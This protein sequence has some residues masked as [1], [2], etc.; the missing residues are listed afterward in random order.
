MKRYVVT[1]AALSALL[2]ACG[3]D[4]PAP[5][6]QPAAQ[7]D[8]AAPSGGEPQKDPAK[9]EDKTQ[10]EKPAEGG[11]PTDPTK[12]T[13]AP[14]TGDALPAL[15]AGAAPPERPALTPSSI[16]TLPADVVA[17]GGTPSLSALVKAFTSQASR[18][19]GVQ[20]PP[21]PIS[22][23]LEQL[24]KEAGIDL[25]WL[26]ADK[27]LRFAVPDPKKYPDAFVLLLPEKAGA[28]FDPKTLPNVKDAAGHLAVIDAD[29]KQIYFDRPVDG[30]V[31]VTTHEPLAKDL[32]GFLGELAAW[33]PKDPLVLDT[34]VE[35]LVR[36][37]GDQLKEAKEMVGAMGGSMAQNPEM[38][39]QI[40][41]LMQVAQTGFALVEGTSR[42]SLSL[43]P[44]GDFPR[45]GL[46]FK[47]IAG[48][49]L[50]KIVK[51]LAGKKLTLAGAVPADAWFVFGYDVP[52]MNYLSDAKAIVDSITRATSSG[53]MQI[54]WS[55]DEKSTLLG[56]LTKVQEYQG[57]QGLSWLRQDGARPF[58][59]EG[60]SDAKDGAALNA[61]I[62]QVGDFLYK[63]LWGEGR[64]AALAQGAPAA[65][66]PENMSFKDFVG[67]VSKN[68]AQMGIGLTVNE[69]KTAAGT[70]IGGLEVKIDWS[71]LPLEGEAKAVAGLLGDSIGVSLA[72]EGQHFAMA[73]GPD[74]AARTARLL[75]GV[76]SAAEVTDPWLAK[77][78]DSAVFALLRP[79]RLLRALVDIVPDLAA[80]RAQIGALPDDPIVLT[81]ASDGAALTID[82]VLPA[83]IIAALATLD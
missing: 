52:G 50:D 42:M 56:L 15:V 59:F 69:S 37:F 9:A 18:V 38:A 24:K 51:D 12:L 77:A 32:A 44:N 35:N 27:P 78:K 53:P 8:A 76:K 66:L 41:P 28:A 83:K 29:G 68:T 74:A 34:S 48:S 54:A 82:A 40:G 23:A 17:V 43:D 2:F 71:R 3:K 62:F 65:E 6:P 64:K 19:E 75:D 5:P 45:I 49:P 67:M 73:F 55:E 60:V 46:A 30:H 10:A 26:D 80:K 7:V 1:T 14:P 70:A 39:A 61:S 22:M 13:A 11:T 33:T 16:A 58:V 57:S 81:G 31:L 20:L 21:D 72:G 4:E 63:K 25:G 47:P 79:A 36:I